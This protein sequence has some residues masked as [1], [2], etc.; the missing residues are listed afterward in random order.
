MSDDDPTGTESD[1]RSERR[2]RFSEIAS[3]LDRSD[4]DEEGDE[5]TDPPEEAERTDAVSETEGRRSPTDDE[6]TEPNEGADA[7]PDAAPDA[8][9]DDLDSWEWLDDW[10]DNADGSDG[11][12]EADRS[13]GSD[14]TESDADPP[15]TD[16]AEPTT[17]DPELPTGKGTERTGV[18]KRD[19]ERDGPGREPTTTARFGAVTEDEP[20]ERGEDV[21]GAG[22]VAPDDGES[23]DADEEADDRRSNAPS[24]DAS[25]R[26]RRL[27]GG[28]STTQ[29]GDRRIDRSEGTTNESDATPNADPFSGA[30]G[31]SDDGYRRPDGL[32]L[33]PG[34]SV[35]IECETRS[36]EKEAACHDLLGLETDGPAPNVV[37]VRYRKMDP[38]RLEWIVERAHRTELI[39]V[40]YTQSIPSSV[41]DAVKT[42]QINNPNDITRLGILVSRTTETMNSDERPTMFGYDSLNVLLEYKD[43]RS[44]FR[45]LHVF[46]GTLNKKETIAHFHADPIAGDP[47]K[48]NTLKPLFDEVVSV[49]SVGVHLE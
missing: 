18:R 36:Q 11:T 20:L 4:A 49:D 29:G 12:V 17:S 44:T 25:A 40:G 3:K 23:A 45:F 34:T 37:L 21:V 31:G 33:A 15:S 5:S 30:P 42:T 22:D 35:L 27:W 16:E 41:A 28:D 47:Q 8:R 14:R 26:K 2:S 46:L 6:T 7:G 13:D 48:I 10:S 39:T 32:D 43:E 19:G 9:A 1:G 24:S 38:E